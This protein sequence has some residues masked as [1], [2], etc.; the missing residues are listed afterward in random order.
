MPSGKGLSSSI[1]TLLLIQRESDSHRAQYVDSN[2]NG[3]AQ[4]FAVYNVEVDGGLGSID[5]GY[6]GGDILESV[7]V[8]D[9]RV[10]KIC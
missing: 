10:T 8:K 7:R 3:V 2:S 5:F 9:T 4:K 1:S 6:G